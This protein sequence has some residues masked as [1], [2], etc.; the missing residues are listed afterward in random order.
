MYTLVQFVEDNILY[1]TPSK[2]ILPIAGGL[3]WAPFKRMGYYKAKII[4][5]G[6]DK[7]KL[8]ETKKKHAVQVDVSKSNDEDHVV[9]VVNSTNSSDD[10]HSCL[11]PAAEEGTNFQLIKNS[12][13]KD[14]S[15][16]KST[17]SKHIDSKS[18][19]MV[20]RSKTLTNETEVIK[21]VPCGENASNDGLHTAEYSGSYCQ[22]TNSSVDED[23]LDKI[24]KIKYENDSAVNIEKKMPKRP[25][26]IISNETVKNQFSQ[27]VNIGDTNIKGMNK[28]DAAIDHVLNY[29]PSNS[30]S[31]KNTDI[32]DTSSEKSNIIKVSPK[33]NKV[34]SPAVTSEQQKKTHKKHQCFY[35]KKL[36][37][38]IVRHWNNVHK[39]ENEVKEI[40]SLPTSNPLRKKKIDLLRKKGD[41]DYNVSV[42]EGSKNHIVARSS[43]KKSAEYLPCP[44]CLGYFNKENIR[45]HKINCSPNHGSRHLQGNCRKLTNYIHEKASSTL[46]NFI[47]PDMYND[48]ITNEVFFDEILI[49]YGNYMC[50]RVGEFHNKDH[51]RAQ[52]RLLGRFML[53]VKVHDNN[54]RNCK[55][56]IHSRNIDTILKAINDIA[57]FDKN[58]CIFK[59]PTNAR[60]LLNEL[61][62]IIGIVE[63][64]SDKT[65]DDVLMKRAAGLSRRIK[66]EL[67]PYINRICKNSENRLRRLKQQKNRKLPDN[68]EIKRYLRVLLRNILSYKRKLKENF[69]LR[70]WINLAETLLVYLAVFNRKRPGETQRIEIADF[71][72]REVVDEGDLKNLDKRDKIQAEKYARIGFRGK[73]GNSTA[74]LIEKKNILPGIELLLKY[75]KEAGVHPKNRFLFGRPS[76]TEI[77]ITFETYKC[78]RRF[79]KLAKISSEILSFTKLRKHLATEV[80]KAGTSQEEEMRVS[81]YMSHDF[82]IHKKVYDHSATLVDI[83]KVSKHLE[84]TTDWESPGPSSRLKKKQKPNNEKGNSTDSSNDEDDSIDNLDH[85][86]KG[87]SNDSSSDEDDSINNLDHTRDKLVIQSKVAHKYKNRTMEMRKTRTSDP[88]TTAD[89]EKCLGKFCKRKLWTSEEKEI[90]RKFFWEEINRKRSLNMERVKIFKNQYADTFKQ[91]PLNMIKQWV[92][93][94]KIKVHEQKKGV[95]G[96]KPRYSTPERDILE[97]SLEQHSLEDIE[98][99]IEYFEDIASTN[100]IFKRNR[101]SAESLQRKYKR[102]KMMA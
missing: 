18:N 1:I 13:I 101:R 81:T 11:I 60:T 97:S 29:H 45:R 33:A 20:T 74:L 21:N 73:L 57:Q 5:R 26:I 31:F 32:S 16:N 44:S 70:S 49:T 71:Y 84:R 30:V 62:K 8:L 15:S 35:C 98:P 37:F 95:Q 17:V 36:L 78:H 92:E 63:S 46:R 88:P 79:C 7:K 14:I 12:A 102:L 19:V 96:K 53:R 54:I 61:K 41:Y 56:L 68:S 67:A 69:S 51:I 38:Q 28:N 90:A 80:A 89:V 82:N 47:A 65:E 72:N 86:E 94:E 23:V 83:T 52:L 87:N 66:Q 55:E 42:H 59:H 58:S 2:G 39:E 40:N 22:P 93:K 34:N 85:N 100:E 27:E 64:E 3:V 91:R 25:I 50:I 9:A 77:N 6:T 10:N 76:K 99:S 43:T 75:R 24:T 48:I 4:D